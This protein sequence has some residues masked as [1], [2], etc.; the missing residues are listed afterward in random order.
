MGA[1]NIRPRAGAPRR[2]TVSG[3][4][5][6]RAASPL[7]TWLKRE[8]IALVAM[9]GA[10]ITVLAQ[11]AHQM[12]MAPPVPELLAQ[13]QDF[14]HRLWRP[15]LELAGI[16]VHPHIVA[17]VNA[18]FFMT[19]IGIGGRISARLSGKPLGPLFS[20]RFF[21][22]QTWPSL[23]VFAALCIVFLM[24]SDSAPHQHRLVLFGSEKL[25]SYAYAITVAVG[26]FLG[27]YIG[28][29][30]FHRRLL[31]LAVLV[32]AFVAVNFAVMHSVMG[33]GG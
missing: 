7:F 31:R 16:D 1:S 4:R 18:S 21:E 2:P 15:P 22:D 23:L 5:A 25:G 6:P 30:E 26:F 28:H 24:G 20:G 27:D 9:T 33:V 17:A 10:A 19:M 3:P 29:R 8:A 11:L 13:W 32:A 12:P 14:M